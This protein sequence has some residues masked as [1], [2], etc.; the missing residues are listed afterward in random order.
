MGLLGPSACP[1]VNPT[2]PPFREVR[3]GS[4]KLGG[5]GWQVRSLCT[6]V[7]V[8]PPCPPSHGKLLKARTSR[9]LVLPEAGSCWHQFGQWLPC[10]KG[11]GRGCI[12]LKPQTSRHP[13]RGSGKSLLRGSAG[14]AG[15]AAPA[16]PSGQACLWVSCCEDP[17]SSRRCRCGRGCFSTQTLLRAPETNLNGSLARTAESPFLTTDW[18]QRWGFPG[19]IC[20]HPVSSQ[21][22]GAGGPGARKSSRRLD[23]GANGAS[24]AP[25]G[26]SLNFVFQFMYILGIC[27]IIELIGGV[28]ALIFRNQVGLWR[29]CQPH[30]C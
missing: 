5:R 24:L 20:P 29:R 13:L 12:S 15:D 14:R 26:E 2:W 23:L 9:V 8:C 30:V 16:C 21:E 1:G 27:L 10:D 4:P 19:N 3:T 22:E 25:L 18:L 7:C 17:L 11:Q 6:H 28:V